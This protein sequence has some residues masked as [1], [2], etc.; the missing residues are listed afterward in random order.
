MIIY[1]LRNKRTGLYLTW[2]PSPAHEGH[3]T[4][5]G[6]FWKR[7]DTAKKHADSLMHEWVSTLSKSGLYYFW[8]KAGYLKE[9]EGTFE[10]VCHDVTMSN[11]KI[12]PI[13]NLIGETKCQK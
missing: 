10:I 4:E 2:L 13:E 9:R 12:I 8:V 5:T 1:R 7:I 11:E 6:T 3:W